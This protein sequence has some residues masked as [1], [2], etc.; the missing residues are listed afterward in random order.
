V[1]QRPACRGAALLALTPQDNCEKYGK[2]ITIIKVW[3]SG[4]NPLE[5]IF[6]TVPGDKLT[7]PKSLVT[8]ISYLTFI[9]HRRLIL[10]GNPCRATLNSIG[11]KRRPV[12][13]LPVNESYANDNNH[14]P[15][16]NRQSIA[17]F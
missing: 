10:D 5:S 14:G 17:R 16:A 2:P 13:A 9:F 1:V 15:A 11:N 12:A 3:K 7:S 8:S 4:K 6:V